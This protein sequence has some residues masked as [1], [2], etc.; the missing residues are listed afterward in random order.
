VYEAMLDRN[1]S[2]VASMVARLRD[3]C[4]RGLWVPRRNAVIDELA[5]AAARTAPAEARS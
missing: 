1:P 4:R 3:A 5:A 2:A